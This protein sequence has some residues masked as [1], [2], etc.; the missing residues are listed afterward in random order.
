MDKLYTDYYE[1]LF[2]FCMKLTQNNK[3][4]AEDIVQ[5]TFMRALQNAH[6]FLGM[7]E[8]QQRSWLYKTAKNI[9]IDTARRMANMPNMVMDVKK[10]EDFGAVGVEELL[11]VLTKEERQLYHMRYELGY[12]SK[13]IGEK[14]A[15]PASTI[16]TKLVV[17]RKKL[18]KQYLE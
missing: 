1:K 11:Q 5:E 18:L 16:R 2:W 4:A 14:L 6:I 13:E 17:L 8:M 15:I 7:H 10:E 9:Y 3:E 12:H